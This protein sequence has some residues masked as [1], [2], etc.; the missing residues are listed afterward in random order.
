MSWSVFEV[1]FSAV[2]L[3][4]GK[5]RNVLYINYFSKVGPVH[6]LGKSKKLLDGEVV[7]SKIRV[8]RVAFNKVT[9]W[10]I[11]AK[12]PHGFKVT[13]RCATLSLANTKLAIVRTRM[14]LSNSSFPF[15]VFFFFVF[16]PPWMIIA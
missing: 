10:L 6:F 1:S 11:G 12:F 8:Q 9:D 16:Q 5:Q 3:E 15:I 2:S 14:N 7:N 13:V 4:S